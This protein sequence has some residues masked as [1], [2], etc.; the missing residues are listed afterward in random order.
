MWNRETF[1]CEEPAA[2]IPATITPTAVTAVPRK[3]KRQ[4]S[5]PFPELPSLSTSVESAASASDYDLKEP[6]SDAVNI[7]SP[8]SCLLRTDSSE[9]YRG[10]EKHMTP[11]HLVKLMEDL[12]KNKS[13]TD[14]WMSKRNP[15]TPLNVPAIVEASMPKQSSICS[16]VTSAHQTTPVGSA[17]SHFTEVSAH[18]VVRG[19]TPGQ[20]I[21]TSVRSSSGL[22]S[23]S[24]VPIKAPSPAPKK[25]PK[26]PIF[27]V[28]DSGSDS[29]DSFTSR[30][31]LHKS[32]LSEGLRRRSTEKRTSF[33]SEVS[34]RTFHDDDD[35]CTEDEEVISESAI[36]DE[37]SSDWESSTDSAQSSYN[38][39]TLFQRVESR[40]QLASRR[41]LL[42]TMLHEPK[43]AAALANAG[44]RSTPALRSRTTSP[45]GPSLA[46][47]PRQ[48]SPLASRPYAE[49]T[50]SKPIIMT[51]SNMHP[52]A[53]SPRTTRRN[54]LATELTESLR[55]HLLWERQQK[56][57][58]AAAVLKRRHTAHDVTKLND[59][60]QVNY[61]GKG[62]TSKNNS[63]NHYFDQGLHEYH[64]AG[65]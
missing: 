12:D 43:R 51:T 41:S 13:S 22:A 54:M 53:L 33:R 61:S 45:S 14:G 16:S 4:D 59:Y 50:R 62:N 37:D 1:C 26:K 5:D 47:S 36:E 65:W 60:P 52:P 25:A 32:K 42:S 2:T 17:T 31:R 44:S 49:I 64:V 57:T 7:K 11:V 19:F 48:E 30:H 58:T 27:I 3:P 6:R 9:R 39:Q 56:N 40:P 8:R 55:R 28:G 35:I 38:E 15:I 10:K 34:T 18:S 46:P 23:E 24:V 20:N 63:W 21:S 29:D